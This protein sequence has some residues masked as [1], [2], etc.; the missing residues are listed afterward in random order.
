MPK[1]KFYA[2]NRPD[3]K[4]I[5]TDWVECE[6]MTRGVKGSLFKSFATREEA[7]VW[8]SGVSAKPVEGLKI[9]VD[10]SFAPDF[11]FAGWAFVVVENDVEIDRGLGVSR[12]PAESRNIDGELL[13]A[14]NA[15]RWLDNHQKKGVICHDYEGIARW[16]LGQWK[17]KSAVAIRYI[18]ASRPYV[19]WASFEKVEAHSGNK[20]N[21]LVDSLAK[22]AIEIAKKKRD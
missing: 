17:A 4:H 2:I 10:G 7:E 1:I 3:S 5:V 16:A 14:Y 9:F 20:W 18:E 21:E 12:F 15:M 22:R 6:R 13:A 19:H 8:L 11:P